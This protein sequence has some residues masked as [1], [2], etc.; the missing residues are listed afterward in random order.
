MKVTGKRQDV[1]TN[2]LQPA[3]RDQDIAENRDL[4]CLLQF[5]RELLHVSGK[6]SR[7]RHRFGNR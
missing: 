6:P 4:A 3:R 1:L 2:S 7:F 5:R